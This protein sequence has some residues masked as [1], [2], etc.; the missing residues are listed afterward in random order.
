MTIPMSSV[1]NCLINEP[2]AEFRFRSPNK[3]EAESRSRFPKRPKMG[4]GLLRRPNP[5]PTSMA[6]SMMPSCRSLLQKKSPARM[7]ELAL[8]L[9]EAGPDIN[10]DQDKR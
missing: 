5:R 4:P 8:V 7:P 9:R 1:M 6:R 10:S 2:E 3:P